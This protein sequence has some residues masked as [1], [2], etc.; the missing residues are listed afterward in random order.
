MA[1]FFSSTLSQLQ[2]TIDKNLGIEESQAKEAMGASALSTSQAWKPSMNYMLTPP[3]LCLI[4]FGRFYFIAM[5]V[6]LP[7]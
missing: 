3:E 4:V 5:L 1:D 6:V 2:K 7:L